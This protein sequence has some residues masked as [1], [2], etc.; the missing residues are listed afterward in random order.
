M[1][2][3]FSTILERKGQDA[4]ALDALGVLATAPKAPQA[5]F[6]AIPM[7]VAD[8][9]FPL[10]PGIFD[11]ITERLKL[12]H[13]G[14]FDIR[15]EL[16][17]AVKA[18]QQQ[19]HGRHDLDFV[20]IGYQNGVL[21][22]LAS[23]LKVFC[24]DGDGVLLHSPTYTGFTRVLDNNGY[25]AV[26]SPLKLDSNGIWRMDFA[27]MEKKIKEHKLHTGILCS[28]HNPT[29][30][31]WERA[32]LE[33]LFDL[34]R[35]Y[36]VQVIADEI[37]SDIILSSQPHVAAQTVNEDAKMRTIAL[38]SPS[39]TFSIAGL[40]ASYH[41]IHNPY[42]RD[43]MEKV[44]SLS[45][46]NN[47]NLLSMYAVLGAYTEA[48][49][50]WRQEL[51]QV[52]AGNSEIIA[53]YF[54]TYIP[55]LQF[56]RPQG[57]YMYFVDCSAYCKA[58]QLTLDELLDRAWRVGVAVQDGRYF[59]GNCHF[60]MNFALPTSRVTEALERLHRYVFI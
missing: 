32:E 54:R 6:D 45:N 7:W 26:L 56:S 44:S 22:G 15:P 31:V 40:I 10:F 60:R 29:G 57:T 47:L 36:D 24:N 55:H 3:D 20:D 38:Y 18:W 59:N 34:Y 23:A 46:Y 9:N 50:M 8:M 35:R 12:A 52:L 25:K 58:E 48:G 49:E 19:R 1:Q 21:G 14:Y 16:L 4:K 13:C 42:W 17:Y 11:K 41:I 39:K 43:R 2:Y 27:D 30:R 5:P 51:C 33:E 28:P 53:D 37:W